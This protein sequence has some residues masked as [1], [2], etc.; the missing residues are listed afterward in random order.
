MSNTNAKQD[1]AIENEP[2]KPNLFE[3][4]AIPAFQDN[5]IWLLKH[6]GHAVLVDPGDAAPALTYLHAHRLKLDAILVTHHH[7][8]HIGGIEALLRAYPA[9]VYAPRKENHTFSHHKVSHGDT[10]SLPALELTLQ[11]M[12]TPGH[13]SGHV[14]YYGANCLFCGDTLFGCGCGRLFDGTCSELHASLQKL[15]QLPGTTQVFCAHE[16]T[17]QNIRF[18]RMLDPDNL[19][20]TKREADAIALRKGNQPTL[21]STIALEIETNPFLR[22]DHVDIQNAVASRSS[23]VSTGSGYAHEEAVFCAMRE[24]KNHY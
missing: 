15:A 22:C 24:L 10:V 16:Y 20:L 8:D 23:L 5:Y 17:L 4:V 3:V 21:P 11:V 12:E 19:A 9:T 14:A 18:A 13:T 2:V 6:N 7:S 1:P